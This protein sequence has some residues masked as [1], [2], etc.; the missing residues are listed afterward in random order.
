MGY[1][2]IQSLHSFTFCQMFGPYKVTSF[3]YTFI[4]NFFSENVIDHFKVSFGTKCHF[5]D[6]MTLRLRGFTL[7]TRISEQSGIT[8]QGGSFSDFNKRTGSKVTLIIEQGGKK[9][10]VL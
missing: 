4:L 3:N 2:V 5:W 1:G 6:K 10:K 8:E 7:M 9:S